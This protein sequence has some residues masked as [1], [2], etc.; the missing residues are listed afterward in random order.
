MKDN[1]RNKRFQTAIDHQ[2]SCLQGNPRLAQQIMA[3]SKG[4]QLKMKKKISMV[5]VFAMATVLLMATALAAGL[6]F[7]PRYDA[8]KLANE[9]MLERYGITEPM[10][11]VFYRETTQNDDGS[12]TIT[13]T[14]VE[15]IAQLGVYTVTVTNGKAEAKW[16]NDGEDT[17]GSLASKAWGAE[18]V[19]LLITDYATV[20][21]YLQAGAESSAS[22]SATVTPT[23][24]SEEECEKAATQSKASA[25]NAAQISQVQAKDSAVKALISEYGLTNAQVALLQV[26]DGDETYAFENDTPTI[27]LY[28]HFAQGDQWME[29]DGIYVVTVNLKT[30]AIEDVLYDSGLASNG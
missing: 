9:A 2:L 5:A 22:D 24:P 17:T 23:P 13:Y 19:N 10:M 26:W 11:T 3:A 28:Y 21:S 18:Q 15:G 20:M 12:V 7:S 14:S 6:I 29:K 30:G 8:V 4:E 1:E 16:S 27:S 25:L